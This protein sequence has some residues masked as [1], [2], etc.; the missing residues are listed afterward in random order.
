MMRRHRIINDRCD[1]VRC[2][3]T[4]L[5][6][7]LAIGILVVVSSMT[8]WF[9]ASTLDASRRGTD[10]A[11]HIRLARVVLDR[12][13]TELR[14]AASITV[15]NRVGVRGEA[16]RLWLSSYRVPTREQSKERLPNEPPPPP[17]YDVTKVE[18]KIA[19]HPEIEHPDGWDLPLGLAR[20]ELLIPRPDRVLASEAFEEDPLLIT[21][22]EEMLLTDQFPEDAQ[23]G[24][25][26]SLEPDINW[27][28]LYAPKIRYLRLCYYDGNKWWD[29]WQISGESP[30]PQLVMV[31][32]GFEP[33]PPFDEELG[34]DEVN[35][36]FCTCLNE[37]PVDCVPLADDQFSTVV[38]VS[39]ADP[40]FRSR[41]NRETQALL[42]ELSS[43]V[44]EP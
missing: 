7:V 6:T 31:T 8:Y 41:V 21:T 11:M 10:E 28:E 35:E 33:H 14:Q 42:E 20:V 34:L 5:E 22:D 18:Y 17:E 26:V 29:N 37:E 9:Y 27:E 39:Q 43:E 15:D 25:D 40:L 23:E 12:I 16:E 38:R 13:T 4:L 32:I 30:L 24:G 2:G 44:V 36:E 1:R 19:R 3:V